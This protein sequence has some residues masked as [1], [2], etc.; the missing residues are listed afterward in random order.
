MSIIPKSCTKNAPRGNGRVLLL[1]ISLSIII[2]GLKQINRYIA[3]EG[4]L[5]SKHPYETPKVQVVNLT[6]E[7]SILALSDYW[8]EPLD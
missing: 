1:H 3:M 7:N 2:F 6:E 4:I 5:Q 8:S